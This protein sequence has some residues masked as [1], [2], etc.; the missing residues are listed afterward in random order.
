[1]T[2]LGRTSLLFLLFAQSVW[3]APSEA[4]QRLQSSWAQAMYQSKNKEEQLAKLTEEARARATSTPQDADV[5]IWE[6]IVLAS[7]AGAKG[8][9]GALTLVKEAKLA[10]EQAIAINPKALEGSAYTSLGSLYYQVPAWPLGFGDKTK[11][12]SNLQKALTF[13]P[14]GIDPNYFYGDFLYRQKRYDE[15]ESS[16]NKALAAPARPGRELADTG[17]R[18]EIQSLLQQIK[19]KRGS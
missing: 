5:L 17:R 15:A 19:N 6:G 10:L 3:A 11:A 8:G 4:V 12:E 2:H 9:L 1:M 13:N 16:L 14:N 18:E 7:Y